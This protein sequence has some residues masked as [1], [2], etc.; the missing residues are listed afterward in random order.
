MIIK[1]LKTLFVVFLIIGG[2]AYLKYR[3]VSKAIAEHSNFAPPPESVTSIIAA[4]E[5][6]QDAI[7][8]IASV[9]SSQGVTISAEE[10]GKVVKINFESGVPVKAGEVLVQLD[11]STEEAQLRAAEA[12]LDLAKVNLTRTRNLRPS[13]AVSQSEVD[14]W[15]FQVKQ[16]EAEANEVRTVIAKKTITAP[17]SG[18]TGIRLVNAGQF[19]KQGDPVVPLHALDPV[20]VN[21]TVP[22]QRMG[23]IVEGQTVLVSID[24]FP[25]EKFEAK[26]SAINPQVDAST[27]NLE[28]QATLPNPSEKVRPGMYASVSVILAKE[29]KVIVLPGTAIN[30]AP[31]G[32]SVYV[33]EPTKDKDG[34][35]TLTV[36][37][38]FVTTG[39][40]RGD[41][42]AIR[43][44]ITAGAQ[45]A[46]S[47]LFKLRPGGNVIV[48]NTVTPGNSPAPKPTDT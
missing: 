15:N 2:L 26:V 30:Y 18:R 48:N 43:S 21:F 41:Q 45:I 36:R 29:E 22:Q 9:A 14:N 13:N 31:Y 20:Y 17:F 33:I 8:A 35:D 6:W 10:A 28:V 47:A 11:T 37:Q 23:E 16:G 27:R 32:N 42:V 24:A 46:T 44:G 38:Q 40:T 7:T 1:T 25:N 3:N 19:L 4:E 39:A 34:K 12:K 5:V